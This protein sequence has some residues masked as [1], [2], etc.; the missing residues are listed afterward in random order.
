MGV[1]NCALQTL[2]H[3]KERGRLRL[4]K[5][6]HGDGAENIHPVSILKLLILHY[7]IIEII[8]LDEQ[9]DGVY[10]C[11]T[12]GE[13]VGI[14]RQGDKEVVHLHL[15]FMVAYEV[16]MPSVDHQH[17]GIETGLPAR[18]LQMPEYVDIGRKASD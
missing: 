15:Q 18:L 10:F 8:L 12:I 14:V 5:V 6:K 4:A 9:M 1:D 3:M 2:E 16:L 13:G 17:H 11:R 7:E